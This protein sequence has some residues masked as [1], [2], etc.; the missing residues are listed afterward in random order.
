MTREEL[1]FSISQ[2]LDGTLAADERL[3]LEARLETD[4]QAQA[5]LRQEQALTALLRSVP[6]PRISWD[7]LAERISGAI[8]KQLEERV[9]RASWMLRFRSPAI[10]AAVASVGLIAGISL[11]LLFQARQ[12]VTGTAQTVA[13]VVEGPQEDAPNGPAVTEVSIGPGGTYAKDSSLAPYADE[14][15]SRPSRVVIAAGMPTE[16]APPASPY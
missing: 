9:A 16:E 7:A 8:D 1:E 4:P 11:R 6:A 12:Q 14:I 2:Y 10:L 13:M 5:I 3:A 15:D